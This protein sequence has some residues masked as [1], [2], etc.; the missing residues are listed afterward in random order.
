[1]PAG[2]RKPS[3]PDATATG[4]N[5]DPN[6]TVLVP[7]PSEKQDRTLLNVNPDLLPRAAGPSSPKRP[8]PSNAGNHDRTRLNL[9]PDLAGAIPA[10]RPPPPALEK[11]AGRR[12]RVFVLDAFI[13][14]AVAALIVIAAFALKSRPR[15]VAVEAGPPASAT[16]LPPPASE[17]DQ[18]KSR[19]MMSSG[20]QAVAAQKLSNARWYY[21]QAATLDPRCEACSARLLV[22][23]R[24]M[25]AQVRTATTAAIKDIDAA[26]YDD[27]IRELKKVQ[28]IAR[29]PD[30]KAY[31]EAARWL[32]IAEKRR[33]AE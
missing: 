2:P 16:P 13:A 31:R 18:A 6:A 3:D 14:L 8:Q 15:S 23:Q 1:M 21:E 22:V 11:P 25:V 30:S 4:A 29:D 20:D 32:E 28:E 7:P 17:E 9:N 24:E 27:A 12:L 5:P 26:H 19:E 33:D 10:K